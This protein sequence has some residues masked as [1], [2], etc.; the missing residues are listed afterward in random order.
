MTMHGVRAADPDPVDRGGAPNGGVPNGGVPNGGALNGGVPNGG[1]PNGGALTSADL[2][3]AR[4]M[5]DWFMPATPGFPS[6]SEADPD[7]SVLR[8]VLE[9]FRPVWPEIS[10]ALG[11]ASVQGVDRYLRRLAEQDDETF[12][13]LRVVFVGRYLA[14]RPVWRVLGYTG[15]RPHPI[16]PG[17]AERDLA[18]DILGP[19]IAAGKI[20]RATPVGPPRTPGPVIGEDSSS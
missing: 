4:E 16:Q 14:C 9:Q 20:Y 1:V 17:E 12:E 19:V 11:A 15:R 3:T 18:D 13:L 5:A 8:L 7:E 6:S 10:A 2:A